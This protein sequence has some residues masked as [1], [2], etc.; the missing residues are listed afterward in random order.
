[1]FDKL[2]ESSLQ[3]QGRRAGRYFFVAG[4]IYG[5][6]AMILVLATIVGFRPVLAEEFSLEAML[7]PPPPPSGPPPM[8]VA[9]NTPR[10]VPVPNIFIPP[11]RPIDIPPA[12]EAHRYPVTVSGPFVAGAP[13]RYENG[14]GFIPGGRETSDAGPPPP[15]PAPAPKNEPSPS[16]EVRTSGPRRL[17]EGVLRGT[18]IRKIKP[19][20][21]II[22]KQIKA[23]GPVQ[24]LVTISE[25]GRVIQA[26]ALSGHP[27]LRSAAV[28]AARQWIFTPTTL[29]QVPVKVQG[30]LTFN[31]VLE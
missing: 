26:E 16:A 31:F 18:A 29:S 6:G 19:A 24:V 28:A 3:G 12:T 10:T 30:I 8:S 13:N 25:E 7:A 1:M 22:A 4:V 21:P 14:G 9:V 5:I 27:M 17:S 15:A 11:N 20:Y 23:N 2:I